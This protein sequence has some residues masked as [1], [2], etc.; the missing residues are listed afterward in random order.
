MS[1]DEQS[2]C[3]DRQ[4]Q[5]HRCRADKPFGAEADP[6]AWNSRRSWSDGCSGGE[7]LFEATAYLRETLEPF[8]R[9]LLCAKLD[10]FAQLCRNA[11]LLELVD[12]DRLSQDRVI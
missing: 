3:E 10:G 9:V 4:S 11:G 12:R 2:A 5:R 1:I 7:V 6:A 8:G